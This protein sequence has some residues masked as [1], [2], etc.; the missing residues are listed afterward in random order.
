MD[1]VEKLGLPS[2]AEGLREVVEKHWVE[3]EVGDLEARDDEEKKREVFVRI[4]E[5]AV[6]ADL[7]GKIDDVKAEAV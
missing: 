3:L 6:G 2:S 4:L 5:R 7:E 1:A